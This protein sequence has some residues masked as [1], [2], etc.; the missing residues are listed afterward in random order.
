MT[1]A[2]VMLLAAFLP[3]LLAALMLSMASPAILSRYSRRFLF[4]MAIGVI[5]VLYDDVLQMSLGP[6]PKDYLCFLAINNLAAWTVAGLVIAR[7]MKP[8]RRASR[9]AG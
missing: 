1:S 7:M 3:P 6:Q 8:R 4:V 2:P 9:L 5:I